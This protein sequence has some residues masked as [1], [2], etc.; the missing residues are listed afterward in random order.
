M[1]WMMTNRK[2]HKSVVKIPRS[3][4]EKHGV[5]TAFHKQVKERRLPGKNEC[6]KLLV[7]YMLVDLLLYVF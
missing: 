4:D 5:L 2:S 7:P 3:A 6:E 1:N